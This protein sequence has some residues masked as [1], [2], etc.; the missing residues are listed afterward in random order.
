M[1]TFKKLVIDIV[2][3]CSIIFG[4]SYLI[5]APWASSE[6]YYYQ[7]QRLRKELAGSIDCG[8]IGASYALTAFKP[9]IFQKESGISAYNF[10]ASSMSMRSRYYMM[11]KELARNKLDTIVVEVSFD[12][13]SRKQDLEYGGGDIWT[14]VKLDGFAEAVKYMVSNLTLD[15]AVNVY[16]RCLGQG[17]TYW[18]DRLSGTLPS[19]NESD[20]G[21]YSKPTV[22]VSYDSNDYEELRD[23]VDYSFGYD[24]DTYRCFL[25]LLK[26]VRDS[27]DRVILVST[28]VSEKVLLENKSFD[29]FNVQCQKTADEFGFEY[30]DFNLFKERFLLLDDKTSFADDYHLS[31]NGASAFTEL[32]CKVVF[33]DGFYNKEMSYNTYKEMKTNELYQ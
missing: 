1:Q 31:S 15:D 8:I 9:D 30:Y 20:R 7:D 27:S 23:S 24:E 33:E 21:W 29:S 13:L 10:S 32:F 26:L 11:Q 5:I 16:C 14:I 17:L 12:T 28:P 18:K 19:L 3:F 22:D 25:D 2:I 6:S 4:I